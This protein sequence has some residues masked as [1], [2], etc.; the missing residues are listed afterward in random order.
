MSKSG[1]R[2]KNSAFGFSATS[3]FFLLKIS[4]SSF[5]DSI[6]IFNTSTT[7]N[8]KAES[9]S[10][11]RP[12]A[13]RNHNVSS[14]KTNSIL[15]TY[16]EKLISRT[17]RSFIFLRNQNR[18]SQTRADRWTE[19]PYYFHPLTVL[20]RAHRTVPR[21]SKRHMTRVGLALTSAQNI[22]SYLS[23]NLSTRKSPTFLGSFL[24]QP[25]TRAILS[26]INR[27]IFQKLTEFHFQNKNKPA[28]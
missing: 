20:Y 28:Q 14:Q 6:T 17:Y 18:L 11:N 24:S 3:S 9:F 4:T 2:I 10:E 15:F 26:D 5:V 22:W 1:L 21:R 8:S 19:F 23:P 25:Q 16:A 7:A 12:I 13:A 27:D